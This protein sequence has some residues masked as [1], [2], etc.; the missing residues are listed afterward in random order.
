MLHELLLALSGHPG[1]IFVPSPA[2][3]STPTTYVVAEDFP[4]LHPAERTA[5]NRLARLGFLYSTIR[6]F[7]DRH[8]KRAWNAVLGSR[9]AANAP[10]HEISDPAGLYL[11]ALC[12]A[13]DAVFDEYF[14]V[15]V[16]AESKILSSLDLD[17]DGG[18]TPVSVLEYMFGKV[19]NDHVLHIK[20]SVHDTKNA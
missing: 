13:V 3:P 2:S 6:A 11:L 20:M 17:T 4:F 7:V 5:L 9:T 15:I 12:S 10:R 8:R 19:R 18:R 1:D 14:R 16:Q